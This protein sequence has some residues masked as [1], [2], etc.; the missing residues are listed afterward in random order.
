M[1][2]AV[3]TVETIDDTEPNVY[4]FQNMFAMS[5]WYLETTLEAVQDVIDSY[6]CDDDQVERIHQ[7]VKDIDR[8]DYHNEGWRAWSDLCA[9]C[10]DDA[11]T[12]FSVTDTVV[13]V[14]EEWNGHGV[15]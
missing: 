3:V 13:T 1:R 12:G 5:G 9:I 6:E 8:N 10:F 11:P 14:I 4:V 2:V 7:L 15:G